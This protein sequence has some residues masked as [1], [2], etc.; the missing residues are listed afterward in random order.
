MVERTLRGVIIGITATACGSAAQAA[1]TYFIDSAHTFP[2][3]E[4]DRFAGLSV[5][6]Q[7]GD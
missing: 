3:F 7:R 1:V 4:A 5:E 6:A 2:S